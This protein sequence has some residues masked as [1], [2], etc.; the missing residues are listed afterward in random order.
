MSTVRSI[1]QAAIFQGAAVCALTAFGCGSDKEQPTTIDPVGGGAGDDDAIEMETGEL[2]PLGPT[3]GDMSPGNSSPGLVG[4]VDDE[5]VQQQACADQFV[6]VTERPPVIQF[7]VDTSGSMNWVAGTERLPDAGELSKWQITRDALSTAIAN[8]PDAA[9]VGVS[10]YP[11]TGGGGPECNRPLAAAPIERL[12]PEHRALID[13]V[14]ADQTAQGGTPTHAA[15]EFGIEQLEG[16]TL[17]GSRFLVLITDGI[18]T[19]TLECGGDGQTRVDGAPLVASVDSHFRD[20]E[21]KTFVIGSPGSEPAREEL[22]KMAFVGGTGAAGCSTET[23][24]NCHFDMTSAADFSA[25]LNQ[26]LGDI[27]EATLGCDY[28]VPEP[29]TGRSRLDLNDV[30]VVV[31]SGGMPISE[32]PRAT[33]ADCASGWQYSSDQTSIVL[34]RSTCDELTRLVN[35][36]PELTVRVKFGCAL[37]PT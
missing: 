22:S 14:N 2:T 23:A 35:D 3:D 33:S 18:P 9:A 17:A 4:L 6:G 37:T 31:E 13:Q 27:A 11:N 8:M 32:F 7:V 25:A 24:A 15:Y 29:P 19:F 21:I 28:A 36:D 16:S 34:C 1:L 20:E 10:F 26:A 30:S 12:T 5:G